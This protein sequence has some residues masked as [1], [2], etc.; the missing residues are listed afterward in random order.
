MPVSYWTEQRRTLQGTTQFKT[1]DT[2]FKKNAAFSTPCGQGW[3]NGA[4]DEME[5]YPYI[6]QKSNNTGAIL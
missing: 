5:N 2:P 6:S 4:P 1:L 3:N